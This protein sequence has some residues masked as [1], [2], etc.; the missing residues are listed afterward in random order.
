[1]SLNHTDT[2]CPHCHSESI[3]GKSFETDTDEIWQDM[4][5]LDCDSTWTNTYKLTGYTNLT[6]DS[7]Q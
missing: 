3:E 6:I 5:C 2:L 7:E 4:Y 1:M